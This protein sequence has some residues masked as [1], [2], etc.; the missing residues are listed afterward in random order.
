[1][2]ESLPNGILLSADALRVDHLSYHGYERE[3]SPVLD[4]LATESLT[5][6][7][8]YSCEFAHARSGICPFDG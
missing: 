3:T 1:M 7:N 6:T 4:K 2:A 8:A 5:F